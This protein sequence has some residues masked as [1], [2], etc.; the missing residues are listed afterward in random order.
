LDDFAGYSDAR[1]KIIAAPLCE[2]HNTP[3]D[4][5]LSGEEEEQ[6]KIPGWAT[7]IIK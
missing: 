6:E 2:K 3:R 7:A 5:A 4:T 1:I